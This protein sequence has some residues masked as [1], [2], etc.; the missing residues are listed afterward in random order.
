[1]QTSRQWYVVCFGFMSDRRRPLRMEVS[2]MLACN[3][4]AAVA[5]GRA[6]RYE[7]GVYDERARNCHVMSSNN[8]AKSLELANSHTTRLSRFCSEHPRD[9]YMTQIRYGLMNAPLVQVKFWP[10]WRCFLLRGTCQELL[11]LTQ[12]PLLCK[13]STSE[14][15]KPPQ[16]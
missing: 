2:V 11:R 6:R 3:I 13:S 10:R 14:V 15:R 12:F 16:K 4:K 9:L 5:L 1:M 7:A 8:L